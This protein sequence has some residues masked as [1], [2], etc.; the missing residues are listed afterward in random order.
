MAGRFINPY[1]QF[2]DATPS[3]YSG[4]KLNFYA[5][6]TSTPLNTYTTKALS[7][8]NPNPI[9]LNSAGRPAVDIFLQDLEYKVV[10]TDSNNNVIWTADPVSHRDSLLVAKTLTGSGTPNGSVA[11]TAGSSSILPD[12]YWD[13]TSSILYVCTTTGTSSTAVWTAI[14]A[15]TAAAVIPPPQ[16]RLTLTSGTPVLSGDV[17]AATSVYY[18]P[19]LGNLVPIYNGST[20]VPSVFSELTLTLSSSHVASNIY[21]IFIFSNSGVVTICTGPSWSAG[22]SGSITAGSCARGTGA[23]G[24]VLARVSGVLTNG[25]QITGRNG[26]T[27]YTISANQATYVGSMFMDG[28]NGQVTC[29]ST[30]GQSRK[31][32]IWNSYNRVPITLMVGDSTGSWTNNSAAVRSSN[33]AAANTCTIFTGLAEESFDVSHAQYLL[34]APNPASATHQ[35]IKCGVGFNSTTVFS[36]TQGVVGAS[37]GASASAVQSSATATGKYLAIPQLGISAINALELGNSA[38]S[39]TAQFNG[40]QGNQTMNT[41]WRG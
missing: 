21:D 24:A 23:G 13:Y 32:G 35:T 1:S 28:T 3:V 6:G 8:A 7:V 25:V 17:A 31:W 40:G 15:S 12:F 36:G 10:L 18:T 2:M 4:G 20:F 34:M 22:T 37:T 38:A 27:T 5:T 29:H 9:I 30:W 26:A 11:G 19:Y 41:V 14:N 16:G 39:V 33:G